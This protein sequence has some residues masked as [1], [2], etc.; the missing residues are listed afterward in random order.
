MMGK[1]EWEKE[2]EACRDVVKLLAFTHLI[3]FGL[4]M[5]LEHFIRG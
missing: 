3:A 5:L 4:G 2:A 1:S